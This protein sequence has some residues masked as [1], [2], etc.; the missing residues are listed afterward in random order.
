M[1]NYTKEF[2]IKILFSFTTPNNEE[3]TKSYLLKADLTIIS[4]KPR[5][6]S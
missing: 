2:I 3:I 4:T 6:S 1:I 5:Q